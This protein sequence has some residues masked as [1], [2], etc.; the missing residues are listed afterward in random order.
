MIAP[1]ERSPARDAAI[2]ALLPL[3][4]A[5][6]WSLVALRHALR[7]AGQDP[8][9][10]ELL[11]PG[12]PADLVEAYIDLEDRQMEQAMA[13]QDLQ[14]LRLTERVRFAIALR[15]AAAR[16][17]KQ[18]VRRALALLALPRHARLSARTLARTVDSIWH[19]ADDRSTDFSWYTKRVILSAIYGAT[20]LFWLR[21]QSDDDAATLSFLDRRLADHACF[22]RWQRRTATAIERC[23]PGEA[24]A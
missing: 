9:D 20:L 22:H 11:F 6:G 23:L 8:L 1:P 14:G 2:T 15:L 18:A 21:D 17:H 7:Q 16:P 19:A 12:G 13:A 3:V 4:P 5:E 10:A 24:A